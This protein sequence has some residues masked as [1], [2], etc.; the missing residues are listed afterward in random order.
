MLFRRFVNYGEDITRHYVRASRRANVPHLL[1]GSKSFHKREEVETLRA[2]LQRDRVAGRRAGA[3]RDAQGLAVRDPDN[4]LLRFRHEIGDLHPLAPV[5]E[6]CWR[7]TSAGGARR[8]DLAATAS[9]TEPPAHRGHVQRAAGGGARARGFRASGPAG[10]QVLGER[11]PRCRPGASFETG[12]GISFRGFVE[13]LSRAPS[14]AES[15]EAPMVEEA[16]KA[17]G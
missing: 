16:P 13:E 3:L 10:N 11:V 6:A 15:A 9:R 8:W 2:A 12:G 14:A 7:R 1:V 4:M 5:P 17:C